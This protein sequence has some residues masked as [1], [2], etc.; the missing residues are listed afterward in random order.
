MRKIVL[1][2]F[3]IVGSLQLTAQ[4]ENLTFGTDSTLDVI[5]W[6]IEH[7]PKNGQ[8]TIN[9][10]T[11][12]VEALDV[13]VIA[14]QEVSSEVWLDQLI[15]SLD[16]WDGY[17][18]YSQFVGLA[19][20]YRTAVIE[21]VDIFEIYTNKNR[22]L[23]RAPLVLEMNY[24]G[25]HFVIIN[26][27]FKCCGDG[28]MNLD[29]PWDEETRRFDA[30]N[31]IDE[32]I[33]DNYTNS[34]VILLGDFNDIL[35]DSPAND[36]FQVFKDNPENYLFVD[37][38]IA[39]GGNYNWSYPTWPSHIDHILI[40]ND[41]FEEY[42]SFGSAVET[43]KLDS[44]FGSWYAYE[45]DVSD[46]RPVGVKIKINTNLG[47]DDIAVADIFLNYPNPFKSTTTIHFSPVL[48]NAKVEVFS[49]KQQKIQHIDL[50]VNQSSV[51]WNTD[52]VEAGIYF[53]RL[54]VEGEIIA[55]RKMIVIH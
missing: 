28:Y 2:F 35:T 50:D 41:L 19:Y 26:N 23:P 42:G 53:C 46:H 20:I 6:N 11:Q 55:V 49:M 15:E 45:N 33:A 12:I 52:G 34:K 22:E 38:G 40:T 47:I 8:T 32:Y 3:A 5:T 17:Y 13:D 14:I 44:Y 18:A 16:G 25:E 48:T 24:A 10:V 4:F 1:V 27:H 43:I 21:D 37:M 51:V 31:L 29:D 9:Y 36:V 30:S 39:E 54:I 7:F